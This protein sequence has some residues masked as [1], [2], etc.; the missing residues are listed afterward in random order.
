MALNVLNLSHVAIRKLDGDCN[1]LMHAGGLT[2]H[3][4]TSSGTNSSD[5]SNQYQPHQPLNSAWSSAAPGPVAVAAM[6]QVMEQQHARLLPR[7]HSAANN[8]HTHDTGPA[9]PLGAYSDQLGSAGAGYSSV[10]SIPSTSQPLSKLT[11]FLGSFFR[12]N[13]QP[14]STAA[15]SCKTCKDIPA[16]AAQGP[17]ATHAAERRPS[18]SGASTFMNDAYMNLTSAGEAA[19]QEAAQQLADSA[20]ARQAASRV[21]PHGA[22]SVSQHASILDNP[23][24]SRTALQLP[25]QPAQQQKQPSDFI[26]SAYD[27]QL[28]CQLLEL[29]E[30]P[31]TSAAARIESLLCNSAALSSDSRDPFIMSDIPGQ[32][33]VSLIATS[34]CEPTDITVLEDHDHMDHSGLDVHLLDAT[35]ACADTSAGMQFAGAGNTPAPWTHPA[36]QQP[37]GHRTAAAASMGAGAG[38]VADLH[39]GAEDGCALE[40]SHAELLLKACINPDVVE[41]LAVLTHTD[42]LPFRHQNGAGESVVML[43]LNLFSE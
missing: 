4:A 11:G 43:M 30:P 37:E 9:Q 2:Q 21:R 25:M 35:P 12:G 5:P 17:A 19:R 1:T 31:G 8:Q 20:A 22:M 26:S 32:A 33:A 24:P 7:P 29:A 28:R 3:G 27:A 10:T 39:S 6:Q 42:G 40:E 41:A 36:G 18:T 15:A 34:D 38:P 14:L 23:Q 13:K 16:P